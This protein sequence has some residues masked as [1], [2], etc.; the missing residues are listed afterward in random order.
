MLRA[1]M[2]LDSSYLGENE[3]GHF[4]IEANYFSQSQKLCVDFDSQAKSS[5]KSKLLFRSGRGKYFY[6]FPPRDVVPYIADIG[7]LDDV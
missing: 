7:H 1:R 2:A 6:L 3:F 4:F 5:S